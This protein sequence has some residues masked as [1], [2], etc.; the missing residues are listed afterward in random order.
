MVLLV[1]M[2][3][4]TASGNRAACRAAEL[5]SREVSGVRVPCSPGD[6]CCMSDSTNSNSGMQQDKH[7]RVEPIELCALCRQLVDCWR[8]GLTVGKAH[9]SISKVCDG[10][11]RGRG[12]GGGGNK[13]QV[14][15]G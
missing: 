8:D 3:R 15:R 12:G 9:S 2:A 10:E 13:Q 1:H 6:S 14:Q 11:K 5:E 4:H 7:S